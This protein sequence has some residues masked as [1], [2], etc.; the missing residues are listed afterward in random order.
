MS[1]QERLVPLQQVPFPVLY[2]KGDRAGVI[3]KEETLTLCTAKALKD[4]WY[5]DLLIID[6]RGRAY[7]VANVKKLHGVGLFGGYNLFFNRRLR[8]GLDLIQEPRPYTLNEIKEMIVNA[9]LR[10]DEC[11]AYPHRRELLREVRSA[12]SIREALLCL[13]E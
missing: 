4:G 13:G 5:K 2:V 6:S 11:P 8:V 9:V 10:D 1:T 12:R 7:R 3:Q